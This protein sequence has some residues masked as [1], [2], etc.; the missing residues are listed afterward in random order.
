MPI[1]TGDRPVK[2]VREEVIDQLVINYGHAEI[3]LEAFERR[4]DI[5]MDT[6]DRG[7]ILF[8]YLKAF[9]LYVMYRASLAQSKIRYSAALMNLPQPLSSMALA[10]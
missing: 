6:E 1:K 3:T 10:F 5:A 8:I 9:V 7:A 2:N 4:L